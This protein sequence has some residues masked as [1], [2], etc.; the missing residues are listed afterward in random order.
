[1]T[2]QASLNLS[3]IWDLRRF[4]KLICERF[5]FWHISDKNAIG[6][7]QIRWHY[8]PDKFLYDSHSLS[9]PPNVKWAFIYGFCAE[10]CFILLFT[11]I[12]GCHLSRFW[13]TR[14]LFIETTSSC[15]IYF[16]LHKLSNVILQELKSKHGLKS[17]LNLSTGV[18]KFRYVLNF[19]DV[20]KLLSATTWW[21]LIVQWHQ[22]D[23]KHPQIDSN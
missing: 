5:S 3:S 1:M 18:L 22:Y 19:K 11:V 13:S 2:L 6:F 12:S 14:W 17:Y 8:D 9:L 21:Q 23:A 7:S 20:L 4:D 10:L 15:G 16:V